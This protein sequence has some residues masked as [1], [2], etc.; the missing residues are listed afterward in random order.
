MRAWGLLTT[1]VLFGC[2]DDGGNTPI[3]GSIGDP[4]D[5]ATTDAP[6]SDAYTGP[7]RTIF[8][9]RNGGT[10]TMGMNDSVANTQAFDDMTVVAPPYPFGD[11]EWTATKAC[12]TALFAPF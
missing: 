5:A 6:D 3:D 4:I 9:N 8:L 2:G 7:T 12:V 10:Y 1:L 11:P